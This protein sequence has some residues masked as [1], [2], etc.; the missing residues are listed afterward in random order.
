[1]RHL[2]KGRSCFETPEV[3]LSFSGKLS[4]N[5]VCIYDLSM[6]T[7]ALFQT[8]DPSHVQQVQVLCHVS[9]RFYDLWF[10]DNY[11]VPALTFMDSSFWKLKVRLTVIFDQGNRKFNFYLHG[12]S[13]EH[14]QVFSNIRVLLLNLSVEMGEVLKSSSYKIQIATFLDCT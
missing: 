5:S 7:R 6:H 13:K 1:M 2:E 12:Q 10:C 11:T 8:R 3:T 14:L 9:K 4:E